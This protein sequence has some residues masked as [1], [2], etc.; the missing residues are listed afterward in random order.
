MS[1]MMDQ[2]MGQ[3]GG[4]AMGGPPQSID[5]SSLSAPSGGDSQSFSNPG[6]ALKAAIDALRS[7]V[8]QEKDDIDKQVALEIQA[9]IQSLLAKDQKEL[10]AAQGISDVH[11]G[12]A[13]M[14]R[15]A[16]G[17]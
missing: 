13:Q 2:A 16:Q 4:G 17:Q 1:S 3:M 15:R 6:D 5:L 9:K 7:Y 8:D 10:E 11:R 14:T 12:V